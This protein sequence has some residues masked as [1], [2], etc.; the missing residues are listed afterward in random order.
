MEREYD[1]F[2]RLPNGSPMWRGHASGLHDVRQQLQ[3]IAR[4]T[5]NECF[6]MYIPTKEIVAR[7]NIGTSVGVARKLL[8][9]QIAYNVVLAAQRAEALRLQGYEVVTVFGNDAA[10]VVLRLPQIAILH[11]RTHSPGTSPRRN[12]RVA[13]SEISRCPNPRLKSTY[14]SRAT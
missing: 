10:K 2:G 14:G 11:L 7:L 8:V 5:K 6:A 4:E 3:P 12:G 13:T 1:V 9:F